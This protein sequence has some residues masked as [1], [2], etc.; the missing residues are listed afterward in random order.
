MEARSWL[1]K[2]IPQ[3]HTTNLLLTVFTELAQNISKY[4]S[5]GQITL[6]L[7]SVNNVKKLT[8]HA[9]DSGPGIENVDEAMRD[10][11]STSGTLGLGLPGINR[12]MDDITIN[13]RP[14]QGT[15]IKAVKY[16]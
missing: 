11:F 12:I 4:A 5:R 15:D 13:S 16:L 9:I 2:N 7:L 1:V 10:N 3:E 6:S 8:I 14:D